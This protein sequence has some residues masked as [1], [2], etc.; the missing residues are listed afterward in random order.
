MKQLCVYDIETLPNCFI[1][2]Y[3]IINGKKG[4]FEISARKFDLKELYSFFTSNAYIF[5]GYNCIHYDTPIMNMILD[6]YTKFA[7]Y[8]NYLEFSE[9]VNILSN[10]IIKGDPNSWRKY[11]YMNIFPQIDLMTM[12]ASQALRV[13]LKPLQVT[14]CYPNVQEMTINWSEYI[15]SDKINEL[16]YYCYN[17]VDS[18]KELLSLL[19][20]DLILRKN[21][22]QEFA[23]KCLSKD[24]VGI[25][26]DIFT[27]KI[28]KKLG[29]K[30]P[31][32]LYLYMQNPDKIFVKDYIASCIEFKIKPLQDVH[33][34]YSN[35]VLDSKGFLNGKSP[36][37]EVTINR[38]RH[39]YGLGGLHSINKPAVYTSGNGKIIRDKDVT[40]F[41]PSLSD[42]WFFGP[43]GFL[44]AFVEVIRELKEDRV[45]AKKAK[46]KVKD[47]VYK[48]AL[49]SILGHLRNEY[50]PY[51]APEANVAI[52]VNGQLMLLMLIEECELN[53]IECISSNTD[54]ATFMFDESQE[55]LFE[56]ICSKWETK[57]RMGLE[58]VDYEKLVILA[59]NDYVA[60]K[61][62]W[63]DVKDQ[64]EFT[65]V[66]D[67]VEY[68][69]TIPKLKGDPRIQ[70]KNEY[71]KEKGL[72]ITN[73]RLGKGLDSL[74]VPKALINY[75][76]K[77]IPVEETIKNA[78]S[79]WD[80]I[81]FQKIGKQYKILWKNENQQHINR[82]YVSKKGAYLFKEKK[83]EKYNYKTGKMDIVLSTQNVLK[84]FG[85][86][87]FNTYI[88]KP[89]DEYCI[90]YK[91]YITKARQIINDLEPNQLTL[92]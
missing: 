91:Y 46:D 63:S 48:L 40:G 20:D 69:F 60:F 1:C 44:K 13:G 42:K 3:Q 92:F 2:C 89:I 11:K 7:K 16:I 27:D 39:S 65:S 86:E 31:K 75:Y 85:V 18:T 38:L 30:N 62:G 9:E 17:D 23:I 24:G 55:E 25:G 12:M 36:T 53:G 80:F 57:T 47:S 49:N 35:M 4:Y 78:D 14:M 59:V 64:F 6:N 15:K 71:I 8:E 73:P 61:K 34:W 41:Y 19:K 87:L 10:T 81:S 50:G 66:P 37:G 21:I 5:V 77:G 43:K 33:K 79:I 26:V 70:L 45:K 83:I 29:L 58:A 52:C 74:I 51:Y 22:E 28:C 32:D 54:G 67:S 84:G 56:S 82:Y 68:N 90:N 76:G 88:D 72:F